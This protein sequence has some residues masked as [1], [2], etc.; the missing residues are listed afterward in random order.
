MR[1]PACSCLPETFRLSPRPS[2]ASSKTG[3]GQP[4]SV[5]KRERTRSPC[6][7]WIEWLPGPKHCMSRLWEERRA[8]ES[9]HRARGAEHQDTRRSDDPGASPSLA[10]EGTELDS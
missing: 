9:P 6:S 8:D 7:A 2:P 5:S 10:P 1:S 4:G 3:L